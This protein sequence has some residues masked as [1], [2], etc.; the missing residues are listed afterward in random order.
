M[1]FII[2]H[3][4]KTPNFKTSVFADLDDSQLHQLLDNY[5]K[6]GYSHLVFNIEPRIRQED[7]PTSRFRKYSVLIFA[8]IRPASLDDIIKE[9]K[10]LLPYHK[11]ER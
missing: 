11:P 1:G 9:F 6:C 5:L 7:E 10:K 4:K 3:I 2:K 8:G